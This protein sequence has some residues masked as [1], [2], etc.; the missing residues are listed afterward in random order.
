[1]AG[2]G[3]ESAQ[4]SP[5]KRKRGGPR[6]PRHSTTPHPYTKTAMRAFA[7]AMFE[8]FLALHLFEKM[9]NDVVALIDKNNWMI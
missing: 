1:M 2:Q 8:L 4:S 5:A 6:A 9:N 3:D 7:T